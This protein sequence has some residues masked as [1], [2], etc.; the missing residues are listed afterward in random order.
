MNSTEDSV[1]AKTASIMNIQ[2]NID[3][4]APSSPR[5]NPGTLAFHEVPALTHVVNDATENYHVG[6]LGKWLL[7]ALLTLVLAGAVIYFL[8]VSPYVISALALLFQAH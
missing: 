5:S 3:E 4:F 7:G 6:V 2:T 1:I 8:A